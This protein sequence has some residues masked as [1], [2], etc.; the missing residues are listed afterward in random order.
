MPQ[1]LLFPS[2][3]GIFL[4]LLWEN[5]TASFQTLCYL[6]LLSNPSL[7]ISL[8]HTRQNQVHSSVSATFPLY[9]YNKFQLFYLPVSFKFQNVQQH[10][11]L[12]TSYHIVYFLKIHTLV[13]KSKD[14][15]RHQP[16]NLSY[17]CL[18]FLMGRWSS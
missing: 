3:H 12:Y 15:V 16:C 4:T 18:S 13:I 17:M 8:P 2:K 7:I 5:A 6:H 10:T 9:F 14:P 1:I 11:K